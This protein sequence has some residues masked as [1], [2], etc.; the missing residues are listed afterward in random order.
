MKTSYRLQ[1]TRLQGLTIFPLLFTLLMSGCAGS[2]TKR[3]LGPITGNLQQQTDINLVCEGSPSF[4]L[5]LDSMLV[6][7]PQD[8]A[9]LLSAAKAYSGYST[10]LAECEASDE[11][12]EQVTEKAHRYGIALVQNYLPLEDN[13]S[14]SP[15]GGEEAFN[16]RLNQLNKDNV[17]DVFWGNFAWLTWVQSQ[18]GSPASIVDMAVIEQ[19]MTRLLELDEAYQSGSIHLFFGG[20]YSL[21]P[22]MFGGRPDLSKEHFERALNLSKHRFLMVQ[23]TYAATYARTTMDKE[24]H[25]RLLKEVL[26]FPLKDAPEFALSNQIAKSRAKKLLEEN[27]FGD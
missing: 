3:F 1:R 9:L 20:L 15:S 19:I 18:K 6:S 17:E 7:K 21:K 5:M 13:G 8:K 14:F 26:A 11:R 27:Y 10:A 4:L 25:D 23:T 12:I 16:N 2:L 24:L 22:T